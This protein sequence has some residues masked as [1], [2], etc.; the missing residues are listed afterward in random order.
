MKQAQDGAAGATPAAQGRRNALK[1][2]GRYAAVTAPA[3]T[4]LLAAKTKPVAAQPMSAKDPD[5]GPPISSRQFKTAI[6]PMD[7]TVALGEV[8]SAIAG[9][10]TADP[11]DAVGLCLAAV[12]GLT[13]RVDQLQ[14]EIR[15]L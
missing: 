5:T 15:T 4:L 1:M 11:I 12:K 7:T 8:A 2:F 10:S 13:A 9:I 14:R 6:G 3:V